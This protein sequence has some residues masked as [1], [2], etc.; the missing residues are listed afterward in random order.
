M[1][2]FEIRRSNRDLK[3]L[4]A[5]TVDEDTAAFW[6]HPHPSPLPPLQKKSPFR[7]N[8]F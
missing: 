8:V 5:K 4:T 1:G 3:K 2:T 7:V 6:I